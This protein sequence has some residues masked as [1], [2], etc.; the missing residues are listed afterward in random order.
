M[1]YKNLNDPVEFSNLVPVVINIR[2]PNININIL[3]PAK[4]EVKIR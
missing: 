3:F 2:N 4:G 1:R